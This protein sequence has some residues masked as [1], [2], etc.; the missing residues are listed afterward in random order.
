MFFLSENKLVFKIKNNTCLYLLS[1]WSKCFK[2][3]S[4]DLV[5]L[6]SPVQE[7]LKES[8]FLI[9]VV[10][11]NEEPN[12]ETIWGKMAFDLSPGRHYI[13]KSPTYWNSTCALI[14]SRFPK[15]VSGIVSLMSSRS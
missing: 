9:S 6:V 7:E 3:F 10:E 4:N 5:S 8:S 2:L 12:R 11:T 15:H 1:S 13:C 14:Q